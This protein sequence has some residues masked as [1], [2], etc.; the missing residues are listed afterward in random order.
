MR[1]LSLRRFESCSPHWLRSRAIV[2]SLPSRQAK[3]TQMA[4]GPRSEPRPAQNPDGYEP[5][6][7]EDLP[8]DEG[9][10]VTAEGPTKSP[11]P[12]GPE[13]RR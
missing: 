3:E 7:V 9:T 2:F 4:D 10:A 11:P 5:P 6:R 12:D 13:W 1:W 8:M